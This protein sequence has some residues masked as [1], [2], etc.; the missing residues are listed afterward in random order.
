MQALTRSDPFPLRRGLTKKKKPAA[1]A[2]VPGTPFKPAGS[3]HFHRGL[4]RSSARKLIN[5]FG[6][7]K[8]MDVVVPVRRG[9]REVK[10]RL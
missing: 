2:S 6:A 8:S 7:F 1:P 4:R 9:D 10:V 3:R 5:A